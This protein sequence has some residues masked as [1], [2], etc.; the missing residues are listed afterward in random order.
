MTSSRWKLDRTARDAPNS[1]MAAAMVSR[2]EVTRS[3]FLTGVLRGSFSGVARDSAGSLK[4][5]IGAGDGIRTRD[6]DLGK[7]ALYQLSYSRLKR[8]LHFGAWGGALSN[9]YV[10]RQWLNLKVNRL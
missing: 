3:L 8:N 10:S 2:A 7:V 5:M 1:W 4:G 6:I 9:L